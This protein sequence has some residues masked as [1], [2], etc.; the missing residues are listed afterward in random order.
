MGLGFS[1]GCPVRRTSLRLLP[2]CLA[3]A[4][5][6]RAEETAPPTWALCANPQTLPQFSALPV[7]PGARENAPTDI[8]ADVLDV[9]KAEQTVFSGNVE[10]IHADQWM[11]TDKVTFGHETEQFVTEGE[12]RYQ[13]KGVRLT[14][15]QAAGDQ[16][17]DTLTLGGVRYQFN[18]QLGNGTAGRAVMKGDVGT[19]T[20]ATYS[21]CPPNQRQWEFVASDIEVDNA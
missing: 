4:G 5:A 13:D 17:T 7:A 20:D 10:L 11:A 3:I 2:L 15:T 16:K 12:V 18:D 8:R 1:W 9:Q 14:A 6:V 19:L 21:T